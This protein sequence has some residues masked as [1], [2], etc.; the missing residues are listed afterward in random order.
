MEKPDRQSS[1]QI[2][3]N[4]SSKLFVSIKFQEK[5]KNK[6]IWPVTPVEFTV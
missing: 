2:M 5:V 3:K 4:R 6:N 1:L